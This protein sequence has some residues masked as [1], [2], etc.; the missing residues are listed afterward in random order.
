ML[1][2]TLNDDTYTIMILG[3]SAAH[4]FEDVQYGVQ[5]RKSQSYVAFKKGEKI[6]R[7]RRTI[8]VSYIA[9]L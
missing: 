3:D 1:L 8:L 5:V 9:S 2:L 7:R 6:R 4:F